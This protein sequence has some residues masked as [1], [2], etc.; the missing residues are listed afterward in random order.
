LSFIASVIRVVDGLR[1]SGFRLQG[2]YGSVVQFR[3]GRGRG[4]GRWR[5]R[6][7]EGERE[8]ERERES[9]ERGP[10]Q[11]ASCLVGR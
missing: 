11:P 2:S 7:R 1:V 6:E 10:V 4:R 5:E 9:R 8:R 3:R